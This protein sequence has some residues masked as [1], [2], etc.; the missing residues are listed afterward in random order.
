M[1]IPRLHEGPRQQ[2]AHPVDNVRQQRRPRDR[3]LFVQNFFVNSVTIGGNRQREVNAKEGCNCPWA[4]LMDPTTACN[5]HC[6][7]CWAANYR[8]RSRSR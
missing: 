7:G 4:I 1:V 8:T 3:R 5:L 6:N 2:L